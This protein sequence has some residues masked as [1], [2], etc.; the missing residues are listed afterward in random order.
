[1]ST[2]QSIDPIT[3]AYAYPL[4]VKQLLRSSLASCPDQQ[5]V[6]RDL[7]RFTYSQFDERISRLANALHRLGVAMGDT[8]AVMD[9]DSHHYLE[10]YF[11]VPMMG[12]VMM[13]VNVRLSPDQIG[14]TI[15]HSGASVV[16]VHSDFLPV[17]NKIRDRLDTVKQ[18]ILLQDSPESS[19]PDS[20]FMEYEVLL[21]ASGTS[22]DFPDFDENSRATT[23]YT[24]GIA[25]LPKG[26]FFSHRQLVLH[27]LSVAVAFTSAG[28]HGRIHRDD[29]YMPMTPMF[30]VH[31]WGAPYVATL[32]GMKQVYP[33][34]YLRS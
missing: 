13:T 7:A 14:Y 31:A 17:L 30:H 33:G 16:V 8:I 10:T 25:G 2:S 15:Q 28:Q 20:F 27:T 24:T 3:S 12:A 34:S 4:R 29:V 21:E 1:M 23:F 26:V 6:Y 9:W 22:F 5:I 11:A 18:F 32:L 19:L